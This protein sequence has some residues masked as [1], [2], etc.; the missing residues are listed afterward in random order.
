MVR[1]ISL[2]VFMR[3]STHCENDSLLGQ[4]VPLL[5]IDVTQNFIILM[6]LAF[7]WQSVGNPGLPWQGIY[8]SY[9]T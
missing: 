9:P 5:N 6:M 2:Y 4:T 7:V 3:I 8:Q 1:K